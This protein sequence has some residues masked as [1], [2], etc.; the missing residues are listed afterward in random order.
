MFSAVLDHVRE[1]GTLKAIGATNG[2]LALLLGAQAIAVAALGSL[3]GSALVITITRAISSPMLTMIVPRWL[4]GATFVVMS[5]MC[6][7]ASSI[8]LARLRHVEPAMVFR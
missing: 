1:Y 8:A 6:L 7:A 2:D 4:V 5:A 3:L